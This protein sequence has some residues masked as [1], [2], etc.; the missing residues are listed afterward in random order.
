[1]RP[2]VVMLLLVLLSGCPKFDAPPQATIIDLEDGVLPDRTFP[3]DIVWHEP[4]DP[5]TL[6]L[7]IVRFD[8]DPE[9]NLLP[10]AEVFFEGTA[11]GA[12]PGGD[13]MLSP[14]ATLSPDFVAYSISMPPAKPLPVATQL[15]LVI[16]SGLRDQKG[17]AWTVPQVIKFSYA[18]SCVE[19]EGKPTVFP[20]S[21]VHFVL[22]NVENP[23]S[24][25]LQIFADFRVNPMTGAFV[26][27]FT[28][29][30][31]DA[32]IDCSPFGFSCT[33]DEAC[34]TVP[35]REAKC[36]PPSERAASTD[37]Y[38]DFT[39]NN[40]PPEG[41]SFTI[42]GC[43]QDQA[44][45]SFALANQPASLQVQSPPV[46]VEGIEFNLTIRDEGGV[47][48]TLGSFKAANVS[49]GETPFGPASGTVVLRDVPA[50]EVPPGLPAPPE[51]P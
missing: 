32:S 33:A 21:T 46:T 36:V 9:G 30:D 31:R 28:N 24:T 41:Y 22:V 43:V 17:N 16:D 15:A 19:G 11:A 38:V 35:V 4:I 13:P 26:G 10:E 25:Q 37:A 6:R 5:A 44:D 2:I 1:M 20:E 27:Q 51:L 48:R 40:T 42:K 12:E 50:G 14:N 47:L 8:T 7:R 29:A 18:L 23:L 34:Q 45:G 39:F 49:L 3:V